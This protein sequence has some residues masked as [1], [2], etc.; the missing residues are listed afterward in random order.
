[1]NKPARVGRKSLSV[2][3]LDA[4]VVS[5]MDSHSRF[6]LRPGT[7]VPELGYILQREA[8]FDSALVQLVERGLTSLCC[9]RLAETFQ[10]TFVGQYP[11]EAIIMVLIKLSR[12]KARRE[13]GSCPRIQPSSENVSISILF[14]RIGPKATGPTRRVVDQVFDVALSGRD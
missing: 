7:N 5:E 12:V 14:L 4:L 1:M 2:Q 10:R 11:A 6:V 8:G 13:V 3:Y 9:D